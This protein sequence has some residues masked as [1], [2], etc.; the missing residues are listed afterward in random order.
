[1]AAQDIAYVELYTSDVRETVDYFVTFMGFTQV[2]ECI[3]SRNRSAWLRQGSAHLIA[4]EGACA[5]EFVARHG[6]G[7][8]D[9]AFICDEV[10]QTVDSAQAAGASIVASEE[11]CPAVS[12]FGDVRHTLVARGA[13]MR[14]PGQRSWVPTAAGP[15]RASG[16]IQLLDHVAVCVEGGTLAEWV[17]FYT[18]GFGLE[19]YSSEFIEVGSQAMDSVVVRNPSGGITFTIL[20]P[21]LTRN[22]GQVDD[23]LL[24]NAGAG[25]QHLAFRVDKIVAAV[26]EFRD[27]GVDFLNIPAVYYDL[28]ADRLPGLRAEIADLRAAD[29]LADRDSWGYLLQLFTRSPYE[30]NTLF[31]EL[32]ERRGARGFGSA[33]IK[34]LYEAVERERTATL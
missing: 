7:I 15:A 16:R 1:M 12:G 22:P 21:V 9:I 25:V 18:D 31:Y 8:A 3:G 19:R 14:V 34:A 32:V 33:N 30:R 23:F 29:L 6:D 24:K 20:E 2:A 13:Q 4:T 10:G 27:A 5:A 28:L 26:H 17:R 11:G